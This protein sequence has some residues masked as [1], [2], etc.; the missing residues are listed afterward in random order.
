MQNL[1]ELK[2]II[3]SSLRVHIYYLIIKLLIIRFSSLLHSWSSVESKIMIFFIEA[4]E[5]V[6]MI[7][8]IKQELAELSIRLPKLCELSD[9]HIVT[10]DNLLI[11]KHEFSS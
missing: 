6:P 10:Y 4:C 2:E 5:H 7:S 8:V 9:M 11:S 3:A 1:P